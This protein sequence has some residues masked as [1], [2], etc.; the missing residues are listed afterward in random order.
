[1]SAD[2]Y[3]RDFFAWA[4]HQA[5]LLRQG[6]LAAA[7]LAHIA[8]EIESMGRGER[9]ELTNRLA[10]LILHL[11]KWSRQ[12]ARRGSSWTRTI[13]EQRRRVARHMRDN[14]SLKSALS[15]A[16]DD[17]YGDALIAAVD[18]TGLPETAFP[19]VCPWDFAT[20]MDEGFWPDETSAPKSPPDQSSPPAA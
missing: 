6:D 15:Q 3:E 10:V 7:D 19:P 12:P 8:E 9:N 20:M 13:K 14:P 17:A 11:L 18:E 16:L 1:M 4:N 5:K 2:L